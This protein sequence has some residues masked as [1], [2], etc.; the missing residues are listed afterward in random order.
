MHYMLLVGLFVHNIIYVI[1]V[2]H[3]F[4]EILSSELCV[5][6]KQLD[7]PENVLIFDV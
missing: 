4:M 7:Q 6:S 1:I 3:V 5:C 2:L